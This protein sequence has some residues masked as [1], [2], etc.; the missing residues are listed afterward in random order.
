MAENDN[1]RRGSSSGRMLPDEIANRSFSR[2]MRGVSESDVRAFLRRVA[3][4]VGRLRNEESM[5]R[6]RVAQ[7]EDRTRSPMQLSEQQLL[8]AL[9]EE[10]ARV[11]R[12]AQ[13]AAE[14]IRS[15]A[16]DRA[17]LVRRE[18]QDDARRMRDDAEQ[19]AADRTS[20]VE[21]ATRILR[22]GAELRASTMVQDAENRAAQLMSDAER[23]S[24]EIRERAIRAAEAHLDDVRRSGREMV[25]E[26][27]SVRERILDDFAKRRTLLQTQV[28]ELRAGRERLL[29]AY[30]VVKDTLDAATSALR[31][32]EAR[33]ATELT[34]ED[35]DVTSLLDNAAIDSLELSMNAVFFDQ[36]QLMPDPAPAALT[37]PALPRPEFPELEP[38]VAEDVALLEVIEHEDVLAVATDDVVTEVDTTAEVGTDDD[39]EL[40]EPGAN[41]GVDALFAKLRASRTEAVEEA[42]AVL[43]HDTAPA[44]ATVAADTVDELETAAAG[45]VD[46]EPSVDESAN[47]SNDVRATETEAGLTD[48]GD[49]AGAEGA[50]V[51]EPLMGDDLLRAERAEAIA[52][53]ANGMARKAKR[54]LQDEQ[55]EML[56]ALRKAKRRPESQSVMTARSS[57]IEQWSAI[58]APSVAAVYGAAWASASQTSVPEHAPDALVQ[59]IVDGLVAPWREQLADAIDTDGDNDAVTRVSAR[60]REFRSQGL[61]D[62]VDGALAVAYARGVYD[63]A[64]DGAMLRWVPAKVGRCPD[65]DDNALEMVVKGSPFPT[66]QAFPPAHG[67]CACFLAI[68]QR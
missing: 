64:A 50:E 31:E 32:I 60:F 25:A 18:A 34:N 57:Q 46:A 48:G 9:G 63:A 17:A 56:D 1:A 41:D 6:D 39:A 67:G 38:S 30:K 2:A 24:A 53:A 44:D 21:E 49:S 47:S 54:M 3:E 68:G 61:L 8:D 7:L 4:E 28:D 10:T 40:A 15:K 55:N 27:R 16:E 37:S 59:E 20:E 23:E 43:E 11:L 19:I 12:S 62:A 45:V 52:S 35:I 33:A 13:D 51:A 26:A 36:D 22:E 42:R 5:L 14:E 66:G 29:A 58:V 65:C